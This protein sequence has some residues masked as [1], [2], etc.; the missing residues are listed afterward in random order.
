M[1][2][3]LD[4]TTIKESEISVCFPKCGKGTQDDPAY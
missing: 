3:Y 2:D 1:S 4:S